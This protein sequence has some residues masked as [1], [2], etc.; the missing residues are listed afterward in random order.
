MAAAVC[1]QFPVDKGDAVG[2]ASAARPTMVRWRIVALLMVCVALGHFNRISMSVAG[3]ERILKDHPGY[4]NEMGMVYSAFLL[5]YTIC[6]T[7]GGWFSD[8]FGIRVALMVVGFGSALF[9]AL[10]G[11]T[12]LAFTSAALLIL[13]LIVVRAL[14][15]VLNAPLHPAGARAV[16]AWMPPAGRS[17]ANGLVV[18]AFSIGM[19]ACYLLFGRMM[20]WFGWPGAFLVAGAVTAG[21]TLVW[22]LYAANHPHEHPGVNEEE[23]KLIEGDGVPLPAVQELKS[24]AQ[25]AEQRANV[26]F[27]DTKTPGHDEPGITGT[28]GPAVQ[29]Q[30][31]FGLLSNRSLLCVTLS[32]GTV[33]YFQYLFFYWIQYY[34]ESVLKWDKES[35]RVGSTALV[36]A[37][38]VGMIGGGWLADLV[39]RRCGPHRYRALVPVTGM[40]TSALALVIGLSIPV[41]AVIIGF[42]ALAMLALG[43]SEGSFWTA[44]TELGGSRGAT[45][46]GILNTGGN[47]GGLI[48]PVVTPALSQ[49][50]GWQAGIGLASVVC[51]IGAGLWYWVDLRDRP[52]L[53]RV[54][55]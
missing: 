3:T 4:E 28:R 33:S 1:H 53:E 52:E 35:A 30:G 46:A 12:G 31:F 18:G 13:A 40:V 6:M 36:L 5:T 32:Y 45:A 34:F 54:E 49:F 38:G 42:F 44:A 48:A 21:L 15:G 27:Q 37:M 50:I 20:E 17:G 29:P 11:L 43:T 2:D 14:M 22:A 19:A 16:A 26:T 41:E 9:A 10:T 8:R 23:R 7:P 25:E 55:P 51:L 47:G 39:R 24:F